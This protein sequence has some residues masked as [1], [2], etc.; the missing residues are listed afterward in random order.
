MLI[1]SSS[2]KIIFN[3]W[4]SV[5][6]INTYEINENNG[7]D[8]KTISWSKDGSW[9]VYVTDKGTAEIISVKNSLKLLYTI[10]EIE[11]TS[12]A[13][14]S[15][16]TK[17][18]LAIGSS[19][20]Q[21]LIYDIKNKCE[22]KRYQRVKS[23]IFKISYLPSDTHFIVGCKSGELKL[24]NNNNTSLMATY[25]LQNYKKITN[26]RCHPEDSHLVSVSSNDGL[27]SIWD[28]QTNT[29]INSFNLHD[30]QVSD[31]IFMP[32]RTDL[33]TSIGWDKKMYIYDTTS[34]ECVIDIEIETIPTS[35][36]IE[37]Q[38]IG[39]VIGTKNGTIIPY[40][41]R[42]MKESIDSYQIHEAAVKHVLFQ[43]INYN[44]L[45]NSEEFIYT[46]TTSYFDKFSEQSALTELD[47]S[48]LDVDTSRKYEPSSS[49]SDSLLSKTRKENLNYKQGSITEGV[50]KL[51][52]HKPNL[53][54]PNHL[55]D[56]FSYLNKN[57]I[58]DTMLQN[59]IVANEDIETCPL[60]MKTVHSKIDRLREDLKFEMQD[61]RS[62]M[63][64]RF[65]D[66]QMLLVKE[67]LQVEYEFNNL[68]ELVN[69]AQN[70]PENI[71][72]QENI[73]LKM[74]NEELKEKLR[75]VES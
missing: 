52:S 30:A 16:N 38:G 61:L 33:I 54:E 65:L 4:T 66:M 68:K 32:L 48:T 1:A 51:L 72:V 12:C 5:E 8:I 42:N 39:L 14:F 3:N 2:N 26:F 13:A 63:N 24:Y 37:P 40:D 49:M 58:T 9:L 74:E 71:L 6:G 60:K 27:I 19:N 21:P 18:F 50:R 22:R 36:D 62:Y 43:R 45:S 31:A 44:N 35:L 56:N 64:M 25:R 70:L 73:K 20:G 67:F 41:L 57:S 10:L 59:E 28:I 46:E 47:I 34:N 53:L 75:N 15:H 17:R 23:P 11:Q 7:N 55:E 69:G 29:T